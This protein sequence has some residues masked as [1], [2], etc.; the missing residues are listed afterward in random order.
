MTR[1]FSGIK[2]SGELQLGNYLGAVRNWVGIQERAD[3][4]FCVVDLHAITVPHDPEELRRN[5][6]EMAMGLLAAGID[7]DRSILFVQSHLHEHAECTWLFNCVSG[8]GE[9]GRMPL[10][11]AAADAAAARDESVSVGMFDYP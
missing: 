1:V 11:K 8:L 9:L 2:P 7:P 6:L 4:V 3:A 10:Y 5:T